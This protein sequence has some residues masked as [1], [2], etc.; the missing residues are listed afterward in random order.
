MVIS[1]PCLIGIRTSKSKANS[2][3]KDFSNPLMV[4]SLP[5][6]VWFLADFM[7]GL[8][9]RA[10][11]APPRFVISS[12]SSHHSGTNVA[13]AKVVLLSAGGTDPIAVMTNGSRLDDGRVCREMVEEF[14]PPKIFASI[15]GMEHDQL[16]TEFN[17]RT[18]R[19][20]SLS[21]EVRIRAEYNVKEKRRLKSVVERQGELMKVR[22]GEIENLKAQLLL[23]E[24]EAAEAIRLRTENSNF[25]AVEKSLRDKTNTLKER[26]TILKKERNALDVK[27]TELETLAV[28]KERELT[29]LNALITFV[30]SQNDNLVDRVHELETSSF[31]LQEKVTMYENCM[32]QLEKFQ[33][34]RMKVVNDKFYKLC[35]DFVEIALHLEEMFYPHLLTI[36]SSHRWLLTHGMQLAIV[37]CLNSPKYLSAL[38]A[39]IGKAIEKGMQD[40]LSAGIVHGREGKVLIDV[41]AHNPSAE[42]DYTSTL[43]QLRGV[44]FSLI[45]ELK[46]NKD[47]SVE[48]VQRIRE[49]IT[50]QRSALCDVFVPLAEPFSAAVL[51]G[52][53]G[54]SDIVS[55]TTNTNTALSI[56]FS[57]ASFIAPISVDDYKV[58]GT[59]DH[60]VADGNVASFPNVDDAELNIPSDL[61]T[62]FSKIFCLGYM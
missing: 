35:T 60:A 41:A 56:T 55:A 62:V 45:A 5:K 24:A 26:N 12:D 10:I 39:A 59:D 13:E 57:S 52:T 42:V 53:D 30:K 51:T 22:K 15:R 21:A 32:D 7:A 2:F 54:T 9:L 1:S 25:E 16:F 49:N 4:D 48:T 43:K 38:G 19:Q 34:D 36:V 17:V 47:A 29:D 3:S 33:D 27:V 44:N 61:F 14:A 46:S 23:R 28:G 50:N 18:A 31:R 58:V 8:N 40:G 11:R 37:K 20:M 6:T